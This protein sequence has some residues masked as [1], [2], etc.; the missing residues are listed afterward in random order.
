MTGESAQLYSPLRLLD[1]FVALVAWSMAIALFVTVGWRA[2]QPVDPQG[3]VSMLTCRQPWL[4][5]G[6]MAALGA[7]VSALAT[8]LIGR[9]LA[10]AGAFAMCL[11]MAV[12]NLRGQTLE[13]ILIGL[14]DRTADTRPNLAASFL[15]EAIV[16]SMLLI[17]VLILS[18]LVL[19]W[20]YGWSAAGG[21]AMAVT[22]MPGI[23]RW[24]REPGDAEDGSRSSVGT[25]H[26]AFTAVV[27]FVLIGI[28]SNGAPLSAIK[29]GQVYF[30]IAA[31]FCIAG[32]FAH[33]RFPARSPWWTLR[34]VPL[35]TV[36]AYVWA[37]VMG[38]G[39]AGSLP[40]NIPPSVFLRALP[41]EY[42]A[43]GTLGS[44]LAF[45]WS[46]HL[47]AAHQAAQNAAPKKRG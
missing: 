24:L 28:F 43:L 13:S 8:V 17:A 15:F 32:Y 18:G 11:G 12:A 23:G 2:L 35:V 14:A 27:A 29:H 26:T 36:A 33:G 9:R 39:K 40:A 1:R 38:P 20:C 10:D 4:M 42:I 46:R 6:Q 31:G 45:W 19:R 30:A 25:A 41:L 47:Y 3:A 7:V 34:A 5:V 16:W 21:A 37:M 44:I 22:D